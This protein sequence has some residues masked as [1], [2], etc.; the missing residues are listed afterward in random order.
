MW[1]KTPDQWQEAVDAAALMLQLKAARFYGLVST[2]VEIDAARCRH[3]LDAGR[4]A[5]HLPR[6]ERL[7]RGLDGALDRERPRGEVAQAHMP[8]IH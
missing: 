6:L 4:Q 1:P 8:P 5:G 2:D 3:I 7:Q